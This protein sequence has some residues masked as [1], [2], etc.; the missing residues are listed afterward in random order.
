MCVEKGW[1]DHVE[2]Y[3]NA[4][5]H[6]E[7]FHQIKLFLAEHRNVHVPVPEDGSLII[8]A[9]CHVIQNIGLLTADLKL[10]Q[11]GSCEA[12]VADAIDKHVVATEMMFT[13]EPSDATK[14]E[15]AALQARLADVYA[16]IGVAKHAREF[17]ETTAAS[18]VELRKSWEKL[19][20]AL[21]AL[22]AKESE[23]YDEV[24]RTKLQAIS[25]EEFTSTT[26]NWK[27]IGL[28]LATEYSQ[29]TFESLVEKGQL[30]AQGLKKIA[31]GMQNGSN[32]L[33]GYSGSL[34]SFDELMAWMKA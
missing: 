8:R 3:L 33:D 13:V 32:Y 5:A 34:E 19:D 22:P 30:T 17:Y 11:V 27:E 10:E 23:Q 14:L 1:K 25:F 7:V 9:A 29:S 20:S 2:K 21:G 28:H 26:S 4:D 31:G 16:V 24:L 18:T 12:M 15:L 6:E